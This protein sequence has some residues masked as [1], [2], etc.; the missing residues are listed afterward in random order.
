[1]KRRLRSVSPLK[2]GITLGV[3]YGVLSLIV[4]VPLFLVF[5]LIGAASATKGGGPAFPALFSGVF[6][7]FLPFVYAVIGF[8]AGV[9]MAFIYNLVAKWTGGVEFTTEEVS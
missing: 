5:S 9:I 3:I 7:I 8:I 4:A 6:I 1:M 2:L